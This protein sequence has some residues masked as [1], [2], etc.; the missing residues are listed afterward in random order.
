MGTPDDLK[1]RIVQDPEIMVGKP[2]IRG[3]RIP[4]ETVLSHLIATPDFSDLYA[5]YPRLTEEDLKACLAYA[6]D[7][8][9]RVRKANAPPPSEPKHSKS[10]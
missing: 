10:A 7:R 4:V 8:V 2:T 5:A 1:A 6:R 3:T 9:L